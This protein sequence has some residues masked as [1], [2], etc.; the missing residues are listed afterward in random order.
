VEQLP[1]HEGSQI[2]V[3]KRIKSRV[4][5]ALNIVLAGVVGWFATITPTIWPVVSQALD[6]K[7]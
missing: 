4:A 1:G 5:L 6:M 7:F 3:M 2:L